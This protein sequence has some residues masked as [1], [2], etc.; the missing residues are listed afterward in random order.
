M[1]FSFRHFAAG[2]MEDQTQ[3]LNKRLEEA[4]E[5]KKKMEEEFE[6]S[7]VNYD[8]RRLFVN[9]A[10]AQVNNL[11]RLGATDEQIKAATA[12]GPEMLFTFAEKLQNEAAKSG[13]STFSSNEIDAIIDMPD[14][15][16]AGDMS[17]SEFLERSYGLI[18]PTTGSTQAPERSFWE[19]AFGVNLESE[20]RA[21]ADQ[22]AAYNGYSML[23]LNELARQEAYTSLVPGTY[24]NVIPTVAYDT[25]DVLSDYERQVANAVKTV[26]DSNEYKL[27]LRTPEGQAAAQELVSGAVMR[28]TS[29]YAKKYGSRFLND[30][31]IGVKTRVGEDAFTFLDTEYGTQQAV[32]N[33]IVSALGDELQSGT[34]RANIG[35]KS[36]TFTLDASGMPV[37]GTMEGDPIPEEGL[38]QVWQSAVTTGNINGNIPAEPAAVDA[39]VQEALY[40]V[41]PPSEITVTEL[42]GRAPA[43]MSAAPAQPVMP[44]DMAVEDT[45]DTRE[46]Y[47]EAERNRLQN[48]MARYT[49]E[50]WKAMSRKEREEAGLPVRPIDM[51]FAGGGYFKDE[52]DTEAPD[53]PYV[54]D[55]NETE[56]REYM[57]GLGGRPANPRRQ[58]VDITNYYGVDKDNMDQMLGVFFEM[59]PQM[60]INE[61]DPEAVAEMWREFAG[62]AKTMGAYNDGLTDEFI[63]YWY[64][65]FMFPDGDA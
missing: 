17:V 1:A 45:P 51:W 34:V 44:G 37:S 20:Y 60:G 13:K 3:R 19:K 18:K 27:L 29:A 42:P 65:M 33:A 39:A 64:D 2:F 16:N 28:V 6:R 63:N 56:L 52:I 22:E 50:E 9:N 61:D 8:K 30:E 36:L 14:N 48:N 4:E 32:S 55:M 38:Q 10:M 43:I 35:G 5:Y 41:A 54:P 59:L 25:I 24:F 58:Q 40:G 21:R 47:L 15:F 62:K 12:A 23:D 31:V 7:K 53:R 57:G 26:E 46:Q 11:R 49:K